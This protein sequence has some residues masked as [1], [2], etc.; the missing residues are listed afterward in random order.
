MLGP[1]KLVKNDIQVNFQLVEI[2]PDL[3]APFSSKGIASVLTVSVFT[4]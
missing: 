2:S 3:A 1:W 4:L